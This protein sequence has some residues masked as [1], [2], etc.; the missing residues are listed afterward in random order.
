LLIEFASA[1]DFKLRSEVPQFVYRAVL[2]LAIRISGSLGRLV[3]RPPFS[4]A[5]LVDRPGGDLLGARLL[6][7]EVLL[8][9]DDMLVLAFVF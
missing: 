7:D 3:R 8:A 2:E 6:S 4:S 1:F 5:A 9:F